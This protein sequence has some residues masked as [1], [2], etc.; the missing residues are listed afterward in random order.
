MLSTACARVRE[1]R[2]KRGW[3]QTMLSARTGIAASDISA[4]ER[5]IKYPFAGWRRRLAAAFRVPE[6]ALFPDEV[7]P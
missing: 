6:A 5:G 1:E 3:S 7:A 2:L 4:V